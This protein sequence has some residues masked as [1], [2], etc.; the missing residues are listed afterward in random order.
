MSKESKFN[1]SVL[2][3]GTMI[4]NIKGKPYRVKV[5]Y[6]GGSLKHADPK[7]ELIVLLRDHIQYN[8]IDTGYYKRIEAKGDEQEDFFGLRPNAE[9]CGWS[10]HNYADVIAWGYAEELEVEMIAPEIKHEAD[11]NV[12]LAFQRKDGKIGIQVK[13]SK[14]QLTE[15][16][17]AAQKWLQPTLENFT[18]FT[19]KNPDINEVH[20]FTKANEWEE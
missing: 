7:R 9:D 1:G 12:R 2:F 11:D 8:E 20:Y 5:D 4:I 6:L 15:Y 13:C 17:G 16:L 10:V 19:D 3:N 14:N 18:E